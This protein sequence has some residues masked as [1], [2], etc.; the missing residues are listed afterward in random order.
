MKPKNLFPL[1]IVILLCWYSAPLFSQE[2]RDGDIVYHE[3]RVFGNVVSIGFQVW[4]DT[5]LSLDSYL[6]YGSAP[7]GWRLPTKEE[8]EVLAEYAQQNGNPADFL[9]RKFHFKANEKRIMTTTRKDDWINWA[10]FWE[11]EK[12]D[13]V[14]FFFDKEMAGR[15]ILDIPPIETRYELTGGLKKTF[16]SPL[17]NVSSYEWSFGDGGRSNE[18]TPV[19]QYG[20]EGTYTVSLQVTADGIRRKFSRQTRIS[21]AAGSHENLTSFDP[22]KITMIKT[23]IDIR[24]PHDYNIYGFNRLAAAPLCADENN[25]FYILTARADQTLVLLSLN[26][27]NQFRIMKNNLGKAYP[28]SIAVHHDRIAYLARIGKHRAD[29]RFIDNNGHSTVIMD[30]IDDGDPRGVRNSGRGLVF[31]DENGTIPFGTEAMFAPFSFGRP[32]LLYGGGKWIAFFDHSNS[33]AASNTVVGAYSSDS[34][35]GHSGE[36]LL[37][38]LGEDASEPRLISGWSVSHSFD[39]RAYG[40][41]DYFI[42]MSIGDMYPKDLNAAVY[43]MEGLH[44]TAAVDF[45]GANRFPD[46][47][48]GYDKANNPMYGVAGSPSGVS[49]VLGEIMEVDKNTFAFTYA[50]KPARYGNISTE[51]DELGMLVFDEKLQVSKRIKLRRGSDVEFVKSA[52]YGRNIL[53]AWKTIGI[54]GYWMMLVDKAGNVLQEQTRLPAP[55]FF[56][57]SD[58]FEIS[59]NGDIAWTSAGYGSAVKEGELILFRMP[60]HPST[61]DG[62]DG[63][64]EQDRSLTTTV[65]SLRA[66]VNDL[67]VCAENG[68]KEA[69]IANRTVAGTWEQFD[70]IMNTDGTVS[71]RSKANNLYVC[72]ENGGTEALIA[73]RENIGTWEQFHINNH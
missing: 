51:I 36:L 22:N 52:R 40:N 49:M 21:P 5:R 19:H 31:R 37:A 56:N 61:A 54:P 3:G 32:E 50:M 39:Q 59:Q 11:E 43:D 9:R 7:P 73:N 15:L 1:L 70:L 34:Y 71:L 18:K 48:M 2:Y 67:I 68:G 45:F 41:S 35:N 53:I 17:P 44:Q 24:Y 64:F 69:L 30:N 23:G 10:Y 4:L 65:I 14:N 28:G 47:L 6:G 58:A 27:K 20:T 25:G 72:A 13:G 38:F 16:Y 60:L 62:I 46:A 66:K 26:D 12:F 33:F 57:A 55:V 29:L 63:T 42:K 8:L